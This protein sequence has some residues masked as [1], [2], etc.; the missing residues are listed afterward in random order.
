MRAVAWM[1][2]TSNTLWSQYVTGN[3]SWAIASPTIELFVESYNAVKEDID[4]KR[5]A[6]TTT[7]AART[8]ITATLTSYG[9][10]SGQSGLDVNY[11]H[12]IYNYATSGDEWWLA[13]PRSNDTSGCLFVKGI[14]SCVAG[15]N[16]TNQRTNAVR[17][18]VCIP[19]TTFNAAV[20]S[21]TYT[22][23]DE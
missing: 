12:G 18:I 7:E 10:S 23:T 22:L 8:E 11:N 3:A 4:A 20:A 17:P 1:T 21:G 13:S 2:D 16:I 19:T 9:Y 14:N 15:T 5:K 6:G